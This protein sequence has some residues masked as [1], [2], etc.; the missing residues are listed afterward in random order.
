MRWCRHAV[1]R[2]QD[3]PSGYEANR[4]GGEDADEEA[5]LGGPVI[6]GITIA[7]A[8]VLAAFVAA[9]FLVKR[10]LPEETFQIR[11]YRHDSEP[12]APVRTWFG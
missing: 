2:L 3:A 1:H 11:S 8:A 4:G 10:R 7:T 6:V 9:V 12:S 5:S